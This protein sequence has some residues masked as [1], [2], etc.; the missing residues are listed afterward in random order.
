MIV[1][2]LSAIGTACWLL[3]LYLMGKRNRLAWTLNIASLVPAVAVTFMTGTYPNLVGL[4]F[5]TYISI[6][7]LRA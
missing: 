7:K 6:Q 2:V 5:G 4:A 1:I 3:S